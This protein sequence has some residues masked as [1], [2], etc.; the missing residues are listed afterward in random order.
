M[1]LL[2]AIRKVYKRG[3]DLKV[4]NLTFQNKNMSFDDAAARMSSTDIADQTADLSYEDKLEFFAVAAAHMSSV[5]IAHQLS[6]EDEIEFYALFKQSNVG[7]TSGCR[8][9]GGSCCGK[10]GTKRC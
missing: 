5:D 7:Y 8:F 6:N 2:K 10:F 9:C 1:K 3:F 4:Y